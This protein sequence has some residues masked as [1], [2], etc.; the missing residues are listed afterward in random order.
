MKCCKNNT[1]S[2][3]AEGLDQCYV[4]TGPGCKE[5]QRTAPSYEIGNCQFTTRNQMNA[6]SG[7][8]DGSGLYGV[9]EKD[10]ES[11]RTYESGKV[12]I[13][14]CQRCNQPGA[15]GALHSLLLQEHNR[16]ANLL[17]K[18]NPSWTDVTLFLEARR[19]VMAQIQHITY[20]EFLPTLLGQENV[21]RDGLRLVTGAHYSGYSSTNRAGVY[22]EVAVGAFPAFLSLLPAGMMDES[23]STET[24]INTPALL[25][26][27]KPVSVEFEGNWTP[28]SLAIQRGRDHGIPPYYKFMNLCQA[29]LKLT[30]DRPVT[31]EDLQEAAEFT[32]EQIKYLENIYQS[33]EDIDLLAGALMEK[34]ATGTVFGPTLTCLLTLQFQNLRNSDRFWYENDIPPSSLTIEQLQAIRRV[35]LA[36]LMCEAGGVVKSQSKTFIREDPY[37]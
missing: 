28:I 25:K 2:T 36:G 37:L 14:S 7:F 35:T 11:I 23:V 26:T 30:K 22:N 24:L 6:A 19:I 33:A 32:T 12:D 9:T 3:T 15:V 10:I 20:N 18:Q 5:Y 17:Y 34:P 29:R 31:F 13:K 1:H 16:V 8:I 27:F 4:R 21:Y